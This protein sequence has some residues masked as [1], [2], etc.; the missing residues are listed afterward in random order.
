M[1]EKSSRHPHPEEP[2]HVACQVCLTEIP[3]SV[4]RTAEGEDYVVHFCGLE[5]ME[6]WQQESDAGKEK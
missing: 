5:C 4:A 6:T 1:A 3:R 2:H